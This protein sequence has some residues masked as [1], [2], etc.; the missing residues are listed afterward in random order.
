MLLKTTLYIW[1][2]RLSQKSHAL[3]ETT[4]IFNSWT[5]RN[6]CTVL[7]S[8]LSFYQKHKVGSFENGFGIEISRFSLNSRHNDRPKF[9]LKLIQVLTVQNIFLL[10]VVH[11]NEKVD[12][13]VFYEKT[14]IAYL[15]LTR[16]ERI[17]PT[18][19]TGT[20]TAKYVSFTNLPENSEVDAAL[21]KQ[22]CGVS[23]SKL[24]HIK[25]LSTS[26]CSLVCNSNI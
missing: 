12:N 25:Y 18:I 6:W 21:I 11:K 13:F 1:L 8:G 23:L 14:G 19:P 10:A 15:L 17:F 4:Y 22:I 7:C 24:P 5:F 26:V 9:E 20:K 16:K 3:F 2:L